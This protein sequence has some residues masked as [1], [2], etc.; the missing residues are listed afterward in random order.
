MASPLLRASLYLCLLLAFHPSRGVPCHAAE[1]PQKPNIVVIMAD[2]FGYECIGANGGKSYKTPVLDKLAATGMRFDH[3][4][5]QPLCTP[6]RVQLMTGIYNI[7]NYTTFGQMD[8]R[9]VTF[10]NILK[11]SGYATCIAGKWQLGRDVDLPKK[12][13]FDESCL[14]QHTRRPERYK[15]PGLEINGVE[16]DW[17]NGEYGPDLVNDY[18][19]DFMSRKKDSPFF[20][21]YPM[22]LT[23]A[24]YTATPESSD[25]ADRQQT[26]KKTKRKEAAAQSD[27]NATSYR[28]F[29]DMVAYTDKLVGKLLVRL[30]ELGIRDNTL[31]IFL[32][33]NGTGR[34]TPSQ[35]GDREFI[36]GKGMTTHR[37]MHV[38]LIVSWPAKMRGVGRVSP[39]LVD[40][41][42]ILPTICEAVGVSLPAGLKIDGRSFCAQLRGEPSQPRD[43]YY[44]WY[45]PYDV[46][47]GEF[48][49]NHTHKLYRTGKFFD[50]THDAE[51][52]RP[53]NRESLTG[54]A[55][56]AAKQL[57][58]VLDQFQ[59]ARPAELAK[60]N[61]K[62]KKAA[63]D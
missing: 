54:D 60:P 10:A 45:A 57:Q 51:E 26:P 19:L 46:V 16:R 58:T 21:Y 9:E 48:A 18:A 59:N 62:A 2:D 22:M 29:A 12:F 55:A 32:G 44:C 28:H 33:D 35:L 52:Q 38:P 27:S 5:V 36:G 53:L 11:Q 15:N 3:C 61:K 24:P 20:L 30:D 40:S 43:W 17:S 34:G 7:R 41:T 23:H 63:I 37:G 31:V 14:W 39:D 25:Y 42:D 1:S 49:A 47:V 4:Y 50:L 13:G 8:P 56:T 6:T